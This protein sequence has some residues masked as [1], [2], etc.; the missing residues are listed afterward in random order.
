MNGMVLLQPLQVI[1][2]REGT[3]VVNDG[4]MK[5]VVGEGHDR[6]KG[7]FKKL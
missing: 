4:E 1:L 6:V 5:R 2:G 7:E 3:H